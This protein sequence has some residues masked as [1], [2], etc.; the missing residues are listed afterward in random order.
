MAKNVRSESGAVPARKNVQRASK[1][2][3]QRD[4]YTGT[5]LGISESREARS[6]KALSGGKGQSLSS[7]LHQARPEFLASSASG[8]PET[9]STA[10]HA[11][12]LPAPAGPLG[13]QGCAVEGVV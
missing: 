2:A 1:P 10:G 4:T 8:K 13:W 3:Q 6:A 11:G 7:P 9:A 12:G 5:L